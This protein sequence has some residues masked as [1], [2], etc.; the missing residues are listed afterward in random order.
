MLWEYIAFYWKVWPLLCG[1]KYFHQNI[2]FS[3]QG[4]FVTFHYKKFY[5]ELL[6]QIILFSLGF[7]PFGEVVCYVISLMQPT[8]IYASSFT[9]IAISIERYS[10][11]FL[12]HFIWFFFCTGLTVSGIQIMMVDIETTLLYLTMDFRFSTSTWINLACFNI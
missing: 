6:F 3:L 10:I 2:G 8:S 7:F 1:S 4:L 12:I 9:L 5:V 11:S